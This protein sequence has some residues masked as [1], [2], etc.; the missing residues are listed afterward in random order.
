MGLQLRDATFRRHF[1]LQC[2]ILMQ[3]SLLL[4]MQ[5]GSCVAA[6]L[7]A[8]LRSGGL[9]C[10]PTPLACTRHPRRRRPAAIAAGNRPALPPRDTP[11]WCERPR[12]KDKAGLRAKLL[13]D[14]QARP[15]PA[16]SLA[17]ARTC[18]RTACC[19]VPRGALPVARPTPR[20]R[21]AQN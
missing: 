14:L 19:V 11:Q 17:P 1:L 18:C 4:H 8:R 5:L 20:H 12:L 9:G 10:R 15:S 7:P 6:C 13:E 3:A 16:S 21:P 2:L